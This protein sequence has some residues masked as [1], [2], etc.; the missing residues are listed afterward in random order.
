LH[1]Y[2]KWVRII[3]FGVRRKKNFVGECRLKHDFWV[4]CNIPI[5]AA[6]LWDILQSRGFNSKSLWKGIYDFLWGNL[7]KCVKQY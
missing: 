2:T 4:V 7:L 3:I 6:L 5:I 1:C